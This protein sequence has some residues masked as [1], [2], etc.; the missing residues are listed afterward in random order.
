[1][2]PRRLAQASHVEPP[3]V[4]VQNLDDP[5]RLAELVCSSFPGR[6]FWLQIEAHVPMPFGSCRQARPFRSRLLPVAFSPD[7]LDSSVEAYVFGADLFGFALQALAFE[8][9]PA[10][11]CLPAQA[12]R[13]S[14]ARLRFQV[15]ASMVTPS[16]LSCHTHAFWVEHDD[17]NLLAYVIELIA[18]VRNP[19]AQ[20]S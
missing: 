10:C 8:L 11:R 15:E 9:Q 16:G 4:Y 14:H 19:F 12:S 13:P 20:V 2:D 3:S 5:R 6:A 17:S 7:H 1:M 18:R